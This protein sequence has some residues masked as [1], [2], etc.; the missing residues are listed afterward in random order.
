MTMPFDFT[1]FFT[2][3]TLLVVLPALAFAVVAVRG[4]RRRARRSSH[5]TLSVQR[6]PAA[7]VRVR[8]A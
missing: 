7:D 6:R 5:V 2:G 1:P 4:Y 3:L 8:S